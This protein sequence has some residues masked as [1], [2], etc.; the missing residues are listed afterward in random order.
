M[1]WWRTLLQ[2]PRHFRCND[3]RMKTI[4]ELT[5]MQLCNLPL[6]EEVHL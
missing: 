3:L 1:D 4:E 6:H 5:S 2:E